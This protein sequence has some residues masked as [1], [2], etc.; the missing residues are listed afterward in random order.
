MRESERSLVRRYRDRS[1]V[2]LGV[3]IGAANEAEEALQD[4][5]I[6]TRSWRDATCVGGRATLRYGV[7]YEHPQFG[8]QYNFPREY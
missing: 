2:I 7:R 1:F 5:R 8:I 6:G 3:N 4:K